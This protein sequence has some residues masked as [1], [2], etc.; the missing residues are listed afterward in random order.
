[1]LGNL[2]H[3]LQLFFSACAKTLGAV[4]VGVATGIGMFREKEDHKPETRVESE[5]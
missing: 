2:K 1:V 5:K 3:G 4:M